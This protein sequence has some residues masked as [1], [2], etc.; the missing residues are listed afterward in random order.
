MGAPEVGHLRIGITG[1]VHLAASSVP[2]IHAA[3]VRALRHFSGVH[4]VT[5]L[6]PGTDQLFVRAVRAVGGTYEV[7]LPTRR[8]ADRRNSRLRGRMM[9]RIL[10]RARD[11]S[12]TES[13]LRGRPPFVVASHELLK[14]CDHLI[15]V[16][17]GQHSGV[18]GGTA[19]TVERARQLAIPTTVVWPAGARRKRTRRNN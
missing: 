14:R 5:C 6:A 1:H 4:G 18:P 8:C 19:D 3:L 13:Q 15:A 10:A 17:D 2:L 7:I 9:K 16:W 12:C 11:V